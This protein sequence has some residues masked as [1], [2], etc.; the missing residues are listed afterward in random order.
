[1]GGN[2]WLFHFFNLGPRRNSKSGR[3]HSAV[4]LVRNL[5]DTFELKK[6]PTRLVASRSDSRVTT[7]LNIVWLDRMAL[8]ESLGRNSEQLLTFP[9]TGHVSGK[10]WADSTA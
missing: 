4:A 1:M 2:G 3:P 6:K 5:R 8:R 9:H 7:I 10:P